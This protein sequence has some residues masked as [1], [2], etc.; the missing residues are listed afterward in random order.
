MERAEIFYESVKSPEWLTTGRQM[1]TEI[2]R[3][4]EQAQQKDIPINFTILSPTQE[5]IVAF[6]SQ[7][8]KVRPYFDGTVQEINGVIIFATH[9]SITDDTEYVLGLT[10]NGQL[11]VFCRETSMKSSVDY[12]KTAISHTTRSRGLFNGLG[13]ALQAAY[14]FSEDPINHG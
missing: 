2:I 3:I 11:V 10:N 4:A 8:P 14:P 13:A 9:G 5:E 6:S 7:I 12:I 1:Y